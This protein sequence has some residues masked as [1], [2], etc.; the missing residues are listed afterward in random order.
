MTLNQFAKLA[1]ELAAAP[2]PV[3]RA[4]EHLAAGDVA[5]AAAAAGG[6]YSDAWWSAEFFVRRVA[7]HGATDAPRFTAAAPVARPPMLPMFDE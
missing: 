5:A 1:A 2:A 3:R 6:R 7:D 4:F